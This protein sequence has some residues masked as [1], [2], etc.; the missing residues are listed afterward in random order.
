MSRFTERLSEH[1]SS[2]LAWMWYRGSSFDNLTVSVIMNLNPLQSNMEETQNPLPQTASAVP[3]GATDDLV[4]PELAAT[5]EVGDS[6]EVEV[7]K[8]KA[9]V[10]LGREFAKLD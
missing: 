3:E 4:P 9:M 2:L 6:D 8:T 7:P 5:P 10:S 1:K